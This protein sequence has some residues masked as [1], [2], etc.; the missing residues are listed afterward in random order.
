MSHGAAH[1]V[2]LTARQ[3]DEP[4]PASIDAVVDALYAGR[5]VGLRPIHDELIRTVTGF[6]AD[7]SL[8]PKK[9]Y[10]SVRRD[11]QFAMIQPS[12]STRID[13]GLILRSEVEAADRLES[14]A[15]FNALFTH[16]VRV[17]LVSDID[18]QLRLW[19]QNVYRAAG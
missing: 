15:G 7:V 10:I 6:G 13:V 5:K 18:N 14:A 19:L 4:Q 12:T 1:R 17:H 16:R 9:G 8:M 2:S 11:Q 3:G